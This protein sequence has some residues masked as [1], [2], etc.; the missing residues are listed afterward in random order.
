MAMSVTVETVMGN[1]ENYTTQNAELLALETVKRSVEVDGRM[2]ST[3]QVC[4]QW[5]SVSFIFQKHTFKEVQ[6]KYLNISIPWF[7]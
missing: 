6:A 7:V 4:V 5:T 2:V 1:M 3:E